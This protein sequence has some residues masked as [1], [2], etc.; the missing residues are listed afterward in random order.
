MLKVLMLGVVLAS[1][2]APLP[3]QD[4]KVEIENPWV[5]VIRESDAPRS[6]TPMVKHPASVVVY[7][8]PARQ[9]LIS[10]DGR[11][12]D[13]RRKAGEV[14]YFDAGTYARESVSGQPIRSIV[15]E[16]KDD[17]PGRESP[18]AAMDPVKLDP[19]HHP[20]PFENERVRVLH[21]ILEPHLKSPLHAHPHYVVVYITEL[22]T[23]QTLPDGRVVDNPRKSGDVAW[24]EALQH[25]T[26]NIGEHR[27]EEIQ[28]ELK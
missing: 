3:A 23:T 22:H 14:A 21:T 19:K 11:K 10:P 27:A 18:R 15:V 24:R 9:R 26:E 5:R 16:L 7:L 20:V 6:T 12:R 4:P 8:T 13:I 28:I 1:P 2:A 17:R 25:V